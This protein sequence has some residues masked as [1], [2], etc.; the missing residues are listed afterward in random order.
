MSFMQR[1]WLYIIRKQLKT[2]ILLCISTI[3]LSEFVFKH[4]TNAAAQFFEITL[5]ELEN[6]HADAWMRNKAY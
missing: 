1:A 4:S 6:G 2:L 3:M 5:A